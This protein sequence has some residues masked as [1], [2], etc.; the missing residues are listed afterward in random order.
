MISGL[1]IDLTTV[2]AGTSMP[3]GPH[4]GRQGRAR[5]AAGNVVGSDTF[6][7]LGCPGVS[8]LVSGDL[9]LAMAPSLLAFDIRV[10]LAVALIR[11]PV[12]SAA[13]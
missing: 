4:G 3:E 5:I 10:M 13:P 6:N 8:G 11:C 7:I 1:V 12:A 9:G 2:A